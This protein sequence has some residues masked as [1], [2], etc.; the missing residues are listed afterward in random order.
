MPTAPD[1]RALRL[2]QPDQT[3][4]PSYH[5]MSRQLIKSPGAAPD[6]LGDYLADG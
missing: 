4:L 5:R 2:W 1:R 6:P 3:A